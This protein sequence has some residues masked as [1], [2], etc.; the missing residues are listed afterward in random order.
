MKTDILS[1]IIANKRFEVDFQ[2]RSISLKQLQE[3]VDLSSP[4]RSMTKSLSHS[5][6]GIIAEFKRRSP[7][8]GWI[9]QMATPAI[10]LPAYTI[11]SAAAFSILPDDTFL[12]VNFC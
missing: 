9:N 7:S 10:I 12:C 6:S 3:S 4:V 1:E 11:A 5:S 8:K 2:K